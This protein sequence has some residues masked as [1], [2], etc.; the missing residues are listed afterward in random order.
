MNNFDYSGKATLGQLIEQGFISDTKVPSDWSGFLSPF[1]DNGNYNPDVVLFDQEDTASVVAYPSNPVNVPKQFR[2]GAPIYV[3]AQPFSVTLGVTTVGGAKSAGLVESEMS[4]VYLLQ[5]KTTYAKGSY[6]KTP[7]P[8]EL[9][10]GSIDTESCY[11]TAAD[12]AQQIVAKVEKTF[13]FF[14]DDS[15]Y[16]EATQNLLDDVT[17]KQV[18]VVPFID[19]RGVATFAAEPFPLP[20]TV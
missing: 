14:L 11:L 10:S 6:V 1:D 2:A 7:N 4:P 5:D 15:S 19:C 3:V 18:A 13:T 9:S 12:G 20:S 17:I 8:S 16:S